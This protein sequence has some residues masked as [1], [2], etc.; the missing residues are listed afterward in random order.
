MTLRGWIVIG[1]G[2][3]VLNRDRGG[4]SWILG[5]SLSPRGW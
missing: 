4:L 1:Q 3:M 5:V 2:E